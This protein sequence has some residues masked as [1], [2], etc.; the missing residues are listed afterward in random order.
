VGPRRR[1]K[2]PPTR[3]KITKGMDVSDAGK[4]RDLAAYVNGVL[5][6][7]VMAALVGANVSPPLGAWLRQRGSIGERR[8]GCRAAVAGAR[9]VTSATRGVA[10]LARVVSVRV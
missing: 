3:L 10:D 9:Y 4:V 5:R 1:S 6:V 8:S 2:A 7:I